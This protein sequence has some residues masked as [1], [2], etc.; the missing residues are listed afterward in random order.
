MDKS[1]YKPEEDQIP[2]E[3]DYQASVITCATHDRQTGTAENSHA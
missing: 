2:P 1:D 3:A